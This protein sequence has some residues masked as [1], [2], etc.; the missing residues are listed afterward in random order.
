MS[1]KQVTALISGGASGLGAATAS[2]LVK[3][4]ARVVVADLNRDAFLRVE[5]ASSSNNH[6]SPLKFAKVD[7]MKESEITAALDLAEYE[8]GEEGELK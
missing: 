1:L 6:D 2:Y 7:V 3:N 4:G 5:G 8:F